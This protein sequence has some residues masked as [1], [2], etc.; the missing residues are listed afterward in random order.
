MMEMLVKFTVLLGRV[1][2]LTLTYLNSSI[3]WQAKILAEIM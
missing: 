3:Y 2:M 1:K